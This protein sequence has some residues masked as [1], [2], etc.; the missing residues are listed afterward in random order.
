[1]AQCSEKLI[2]LNNLTEKDFL[3][4]GKELH[5]ILTRSKQISE[6]AIS[7]SEL[8]NNQDA[9][10]DIENLQRVFDLINEYFQQSQ[11]KLH[12]SAEDL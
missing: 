3:T 2:G 9:V 10:E 1:M 8:V 5:A 11:S 12:K 6:T 7:A 4:A